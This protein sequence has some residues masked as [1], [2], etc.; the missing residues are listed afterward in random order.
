MEALLIIF[1]VLVIGL[2]AFT[3]TTIV[4]DQVNERKKQEALE[5]AAANKPV[6]PVKPVEPAE[7][8]TPVQPVQ[9]IVV[10]A[11]TVTTDEESADGQV[12]F[13]AVPKQTHSEKYKALSSEQRGWYDEIAAYAASRTEEI[14]SVITNGYEEYRFY[15]KR[16][17]RFVIKRG[18]IVCEYIIANPNFSRYVSANKVAVKQAATTL[19]IMEAKDV[20]AAKDS[21]DIAVNYLVEERQE[22]KRLERERRKLARQEAAAAKAA[23]TNE[24]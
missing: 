24:N 21:I 18:V 20:G 6:E 8:A 7:P 15:G 3:V 4:A 22:A 5:K 23:K 11:E 14:K 13:A 10:V 9:P 16:V 12:V 1:M 17:I 2:C 19:K